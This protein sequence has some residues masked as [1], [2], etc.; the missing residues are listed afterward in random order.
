MN[1]LSIV[2]Y[3]LIISAF[4]SGI[5]NAQNPSAEP[6]TIPPNALRCQRNTI[7][8]A[9]MKALARTKD[10]RVFVIAHL[11]SGEASQYLNARRLRVV[12]AE[13]DQNSPMS[14]DKLI[15]AE[16]ARVKGHARIDVYL[17][18]ELYFVSYI[19]LNGNFCALC[20]DRKR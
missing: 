12:G 5:A 9:N 7:N 10:E 15:L 6:E 16:G 18:S 3:A 8:I 11:G 20:C 14:R 17:G 4:T 13:F 2:I 19:P 1:K